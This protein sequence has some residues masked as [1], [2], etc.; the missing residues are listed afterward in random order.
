MS[1]IYDGA[2]SWKKLTAFSC[3]KNWMLNLIDAWL[4]S[5]YAYGENS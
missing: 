2:F 3:Y 5:K 1:N 4:N